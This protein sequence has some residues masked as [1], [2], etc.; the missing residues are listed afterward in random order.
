MTQVTIPSHFHG[1][2]G[3]GNGGYTCGVAAAALGRGPAQV[4]LRVPPPLD[5]PL[6][7]ERRG[8]ATVLLDGDVVVAEAR[9]ALLDVTPPE[10]VGFAAAVEARERFDVEEYETR[11]AFPTCF[12]CGPRRPPGEGLHFVPAAIVDR[13][14]LAVSP[15][16]PDGAHA[17]AGGR[18][19]DEIVWAA[20]DCP[21]GLAWI[22]LDTETGPAV[23]GQLAVSI[24]RSPVVGERLVLGGW[25]VRADGRKRYAGSAVWG[26][27]GE[28]LAVGEA[29]WIVLAGDQAARFDARG[30]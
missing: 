14:G 28:V 30:Q 26:A 6:T 4:R 12:T 3:S 5:R 15:W 19:P 21:S 20:L 7:V 24:R 13:P 1:P 27:D 29:T 9:P 17:E 10:P 16:V 8:D 11:H 2:P 23:L 18:I 22:A 25:Q